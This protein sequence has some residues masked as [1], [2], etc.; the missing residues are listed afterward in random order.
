MKT[1]A[2]IRHDAKERVKQYRKDMRAKGY[3]STTIFLSQQHRNELKRLGDEERLTR[4]EAAEHIFNIYLQSNNKTITRTNQEQRK[5][6]TESTAVIDALEQKIKQLEERD[7]K[8]NN[9]FLEIL[10]KMNIIFER[11]SK[12]V[13]KPKQVELFDVPPDPEHIPVNDPSPDTIPFEDETDS[14][15]I[16][17]SEMPEPKSTHDENMPSQLLSDGKN[18]PAYEAWL[19]HRI[20]ALRESGLSWPK[21]MKQLN[22]DG[23]LTIRGKKWSRGNVQAFYNRVKGKIEAQSDKSLPK[24][25]TP[26]QKR[27]KMLDLMRSKTDAELDRLALAGN[28][29]AK[30]ILDERGC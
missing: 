14:V 24:S 11:Q 7:A 4:A 10:S 29:F 19:F 16:L 21:V 28:G 20:T 15:K 27:E 23:A 13:I 8:R 1:G 30:E 25:T 17:P 9:E 3:I 6:T 2:E 12:P 22:S 5:H 26:Q 18:N